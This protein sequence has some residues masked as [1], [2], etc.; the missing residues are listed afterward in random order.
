MIQKKRTTWRSK[1]S[2]ISRWSSLLMVSK[3][4]LGT[5]VSLLET[6]ILDGSFHVQCFNQISFSVKEQEAMKTNTSINQTLEVE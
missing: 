6:Q 1:K 3:Q 2:E 4:A 5:L